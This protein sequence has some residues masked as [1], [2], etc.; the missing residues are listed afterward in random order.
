MK[1]FE[2][3]QSKCWTCIRMKESDEVVTRNDI[4]FGKLGRKLAGK[5]SSRVVR[6]V[7]EASHTLNQ[8]LNCGLILAATG[9]I[10]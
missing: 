4:F 1:M 5:L 6:G 7:G 8:L 2:L 10:G 9:N 3:K